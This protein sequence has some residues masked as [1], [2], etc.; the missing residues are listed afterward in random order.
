MRA[1]SVS[2][3]IIMLKRVTLLLLIAPSIWLA[4]A[5]SLD[6]LGARPMERVIEEMGSFAIRFLLLSLLISPARSLLHWPAL[7][8]IRRRVGLASF[9]Y[10]LAH[11][12]LFALDRE[13]GPIKLIVDIFSYTYLTIGFVALTALLPLAITSSDRMI[14]YL[15]ARRWRWLHRMVYG[16]API[17][18]LHFILES[19]KS[20]IEPFVLG[21]CLFWLLAYRLWQQLGPVRPAM[22]LLL[23]LAATAATALAEALFFALKLGAPIGNILIVNFGLSVGIRPAQVIFYLAL[24]VFIAASARARE[25]R[26]RLRRPVSAATTA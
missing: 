18:L 25:P 12:F 23:G 4:T 19:P 1:P 13:L 11:L 22:V 24:I 3:N 14:T 9:F 2:K 5:L 10:G 8:A 7:I 26:S 6:L 21:G 20:S 15:G 16:I 17:A